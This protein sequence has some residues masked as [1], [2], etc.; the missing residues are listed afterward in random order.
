MGELCIYLYLIA[1]VELVKN[2]KYSATLIINAKIE[3]HE[4]NNN[5]KKRKKG[6]TNKRNE[7]KIDLDNASYKALYLG[8]DLFQL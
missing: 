4:Y 5:S 3:N 1:K 2:D 8:N 7:R 6:K